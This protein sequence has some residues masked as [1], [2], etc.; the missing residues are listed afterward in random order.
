M[1]KKR[2]KPEK[3]EVEQSASSSF[4]LIFER[5]IMS[6]VKVFYICDGEACKEPCFEDCHH[7]TEIEHAKNPHGFYKLST[8]GDEIY[9]WQESIQDTMEVEKE[10]ESN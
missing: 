5:K 6:E 10:D 1:K 4:V 7:T 3:A 9:L 2:R 8:Y